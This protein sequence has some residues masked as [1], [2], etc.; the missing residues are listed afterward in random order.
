MRVFPLY[1]DVNSRNI[2]GESVTAKE[3]GKDLQG[4]RSKSFK[5]LLSGLIEKADVQT[6]AILEAGEKEGG[7][8]LKKE[9]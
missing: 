8:G 4:Y 9:A 7:A 3:L 5:S 1:G 6:C 2:S